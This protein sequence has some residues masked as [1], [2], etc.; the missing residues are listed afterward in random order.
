[1]AMIVP[2]IG[3]LVSV[4]GLEASA[5]ALGLF[6]SVVGVILAAYFVACFGSLFPTSSAAYLDQ[7]FGRSRGHIAVLQIVFGIVPLLLASAGALLAWRPGRRLV[8]LTCLLALSVYPAF[9]LW[10][11]N[12]VSGQKHVVAGFLFAYLLAG[13]ALERLWASQSRVSALSV[14]AGL[15]IWGGVQCYWQDRSWSDSRPLASYLARNMMPG[16]RVV[17]ESPWSYSLY[18]YPT[19]VQSPTDVID[20][21]HPTERQRRDVCQ[22][23]WAVGDP[24]S[25]DL[26]RHVVERCGH[27][28]VLSATTR[29]YYFDTSRLRLT[30]SLAVVGVYRLPRP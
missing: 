10:T 21:R 24:D 9:H 22:I 29:Q 6:V 27:Q 25:S 16:D 14:L 2:L 1:M 26:I 19:M 28:H 7:T 23:R 3:L 17:A 18:L 11:A 15:A 4:R 13:L 12:F 30:G 5:R 20:A 8:V